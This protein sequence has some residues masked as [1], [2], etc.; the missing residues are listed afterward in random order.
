MAQ[1]DHTSHSTENLGHMTVHVL[2]A[3]QDN[4]MYLLV[5]KGTKEAA[6]VDPVHPQEVRK[7]AG[8]V[9]PPLLPGEGVVV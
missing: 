6:V 9:R 2:P 3:L 7:S 1:R 4:Y 8:I 5:D